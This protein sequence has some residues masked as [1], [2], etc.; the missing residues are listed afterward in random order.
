MRGRGS[1]SAHP[2][3]EKPQRLR[4]KLPVDQPTPEIVQP[5]AFHL[6]LGLYFL[7]LFY[8]SWSKYKYMTS[9]MTGDQII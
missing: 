1:V 9:Y 4:Y 6:M 3:L 2:R 8:L 7:K 5:K